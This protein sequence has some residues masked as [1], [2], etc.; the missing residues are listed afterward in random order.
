VAVYVDDAGILAE[1][2]NGSRVH[3][4]RWSHLTADTQEELHEFA[5]RLGLRRE[6]FQPGRPIGDRPSPFWHYDVTSGKR[7]QAF[8]MGAISMPSRELARYCR[9]RAGQPTPSIDHEGAQA[10]DAIPRR[11]RTVP[12]NRCPDCGTAEL[13]CG[14]RVCQACGLLRILA[15][16]GAQP[17]PAAAAS[18]QIEAGS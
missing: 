4:S 14:R 5:E 2:R 12:E 1:V 8:A 11:P 6:W 15:P 9:T 18:P 16:R 3:V 13:T 17:S 7:A 10:E